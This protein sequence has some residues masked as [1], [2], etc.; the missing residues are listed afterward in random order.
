M[1]YHLLRIFLRLVSMI[2]FS[3]LYAL[4]GGLY[5]L[6]YHVIGYRKKVVHKNLTE[7]FPEK[8]PEEIKEIEKR[9]YKFLADNILETCKMGH[10]SAEEMSKRMKFINVEKVNERLRQQQSIALYLGHYANWEWISSMPL[11]LEKS[12]VGAQIYHQLS[13]KDFDR[14]MFENR[15]HF[16]AINVEMR[17]TARFINELASDH[18]VSIIGFIADQSPRKKDSHYFVPF[19]NHNT[20][21]LTGTEKLTKHYK[22]E[23]W[24]VQTRRVKRGYYEAEFILMHD[25]RASLPDFELTNIY[26]RMLE[27]MICQ[28][29]ELYLWSHK[30]FRYATPLSQSPAND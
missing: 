16:G 27:Q 18:K 23:P 4:S 29:P 28:Q 3:V 11:H 7:C 25:D 17:K 1:A 15:E 22:L 21:A 8:S 12:A 19:L 20:P 10:M 24:F 14:V 13:N 6:L 26:Y 5:F 30:R 2:P 9:F